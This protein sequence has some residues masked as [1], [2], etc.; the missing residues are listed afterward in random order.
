MEEDGA[1]NMGAKD[2]CCRMWPARRFIRWPALDDTSSEERENNTS[3][4]V[5]PNS[6]SFTL[7]AQT[8]TTVV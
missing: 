2:C 8:I 7:I 5:T 3:L 6:T 4:D 1:G